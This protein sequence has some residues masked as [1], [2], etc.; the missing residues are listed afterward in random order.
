MI[1]FSGKHLQVHFITIYPFFNT[2]TQ[3]LTALVSVYVYIVAV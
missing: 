3:S 2:C 1:L